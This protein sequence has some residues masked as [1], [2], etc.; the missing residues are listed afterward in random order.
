MMKLRLVILAA[1]FSLPVYADLLPP[2]A[3]DAITRLQ[4]NPDAFDRVDNFC[5]GKKKGDA[6]TLPGNLFEGGGEGRCINEINRTTFTLD[7][8]CQ[9]PATVFI[10]RQIPEEGYVHDAQLCRQQEAAVARGEAPRWNC[11]PH[12][13]KLADQFCR[14]KSVGDVCRVELRYDGQRHSFDGACQHVTE[15]AGFYYQGRRQKTREVIRCEPLKTV[16]RT[17]TPVSWWQKLAQ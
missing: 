8:S 1:C 13:V 11:A 15:T 2:Q 16:T 17:F 9:R 3:A 4:H 14:D 10:Q 7:M 12:P 6:C 5:K